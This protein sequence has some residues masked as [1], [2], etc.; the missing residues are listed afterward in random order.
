MYATLGGPRHPPPE[1]DGAGMFRYVLFVRL[2]WMVHHYSDGRWIGVHEPRTH[3]R[4]LPPTIPNKQ[5][6]QHRPDPARGLLGGALLNEAQLE[7]VALGLAT[8]EVALVHGPPGNMY[9]YMCMYVYSGSWVGVWGV[10][11]VGVGGWMG[12]WGWRV[13]HRPPGKEGVLLWV[14]VVLR[15]LT[16]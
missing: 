5:N 8:E 6:K 12:R 4:F 13:V 15:R 2:P 16:E 9:K 14:V 7:A 1:R 3:A 11:V 10:F